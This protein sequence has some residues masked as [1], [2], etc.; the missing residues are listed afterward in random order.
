MTTCKSFYWRCTTNRPSLHLSL[1]RFKVLGFIVILPLIW[2]GQAV[3]LRHISSTQEVQAQSLCPVDPNGGAFQR[4]S[5]Q[6]HYH[7]APSWENVLDDIHPPMA[8]K[9]QAIFSTCPFCFIAGRNVHGQ[10][11][12]FSMGRQNP[13]NKWDFWGFWG[14]TFLVILTDVAT[15]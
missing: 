4:S 7:E 6:F 3:R 9:L 5:W 12:Q 8:W 2:K 1:L 11:H 10:N 13:I 14:E 15:L